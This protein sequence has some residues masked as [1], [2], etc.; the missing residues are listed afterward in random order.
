MLFDQI[1]TGIDNHQHKFMF[2]FVSGVTTYART[3]EKENREVTGLFRLVLF[4]F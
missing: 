4:L 1:Y 3:C 2:F